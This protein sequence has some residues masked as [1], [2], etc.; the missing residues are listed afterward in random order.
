M[1]I[2]IDIDKHVA[3]H[4]E[5]ISIPP[6]P[7][8][9]HII[10][11]EMQKDYPNIC[12]IQDAI[13]KDISISALVLKTVNSS[14]FG[15]KVRIS[16]ISVAIN[17]LGLNNTINIAMGIVLATAFEKQHEAPI[18][19]WESPSNIALVAAALAKQLTNVPSDDAYILGLFHNAGHA[20]LSQKYKDYNQFMIDHI[21]LEDDP[22]TAFEDKRYNLDHA[23]LGYYLAS[24]WGLPNYI[25]FVI[26]N[27]HNASD[28]IGFDCKDSAKKHDGILMSNLLCV[29][30]MA[31]HIDKR[32]WSAEEDHEWNRVKADVLGYLSLSEEDFN[33]IR[34][35]MLEQ[36]DLKT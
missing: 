22:I 31:E 10:N 3:K 9:L 27:H 34:S 15:L 36:L 16:S 24:S 20:L 32:F 12:I 11:S 5:G 19:F 23:S 33:D 6:M 28:Y 17:M 2:E 13:Q 35:D 8:I 18:H 1:T 29:L 30:K 4:L 21:N 14:F 7:D 25:K 26:L